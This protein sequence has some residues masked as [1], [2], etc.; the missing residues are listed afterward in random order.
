MLDDNSIQE[1]IEKFNTPVPRYTSYPTA[2]EWSDD[3]NES[4]FFSGLQAMH[5]ENPVSLY[6]HLPFCENLCLYCGCNVLIS[7]KKE[8][9]EPY[10]ENLFKEIRYKINHIGFKPHLRQLH[11]G[12]GTPNYLRIRDWQRLM[13]VLHDNFIFEPD[14]EQSIEMDPMVL[15]VDY[16]KEIYN[17]GFNRVSYGIQDLNPAT[18][19]HVNRPQNVEHL[20]VVLNESRKAGFDSVNIDLIYGLPYQNLQNYQKNLDW[21]REHKPDRMAMFS[22]AHVPWMKHHQKRLNSDAMPEPTEKL[23]IYLEARKQFFEMGYRQIGMDHFALKEDSLCKALDE[24]SLHRNFMG[25]STH[26]SLDMLAFG[27]SA[28]AQ[29]QGVFAQNHLKLKAY[30]AAIE[31]EKGWFEK[32]YTMTRD[33]R[34]RSDIIQSLMGGFYLDINRIENQWGVNFKK[35]FS[36]ELQK[37]QPYADEGLIELKPG[38]IQITETG[39]YAMRHIASAFDA[40]R[41]QGATRAFSKGI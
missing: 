10:I 23:R 29:V 13:K 21:V 1:L 3:F 14:I 34:V 40:Y 33:D 2:L 12:G 5:P 6:I 37:L 8:I 31:S 27:T 22:Y 32:G 17:L 39:V 11:F 15:D 16:L 7:R 25:Y 4:N 26:A 35:D 19:E 18:L 38:H 36:S 28:I 20:D 30:S 41:T 24:H 9:V